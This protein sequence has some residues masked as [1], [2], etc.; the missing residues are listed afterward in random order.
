MINLPLGTEGPGDG[1]SSSMSSGSESFSV[2][3]ATLR[4]TVCKMVALLVLSMF[5]RLRRGM[6]V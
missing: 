5:L 1:G 2:S 4:K 3:E 6:A